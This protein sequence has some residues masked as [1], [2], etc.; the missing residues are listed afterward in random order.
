MG[1]RRQIRLRR[2]PGF[3]GQSRTL[4]D[5]YYNR[6]RDYDPTTGRYIQADPIGLNGGANVYGY[7]GGNPVN[8]VDPDGLEKINLFGPDAG[9]FQTVYGVNGIFRG[10]A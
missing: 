5:L 2:A 7:V 6:Y 9:G 8:W 4:A 10:S 3:P 1:R